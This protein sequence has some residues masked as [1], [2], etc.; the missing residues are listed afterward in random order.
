MRPLDEYRAC[1]RPR[2]EMLPAGLR[3]P[4]A[5]LR[6]YINAFPAQADRTVQPFFRDAAAVI[7]TF[8]GVEIP[9][10]VDAGA[11]RLA[12]CRAGRAGVDAGRARSAPA[13]VDGC[14]ER[15]ERQVG[16]D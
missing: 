8:E 7:A 2:R 15:L 1:D 6:A 4:Y 3:F 11:P 10:P 12:G 13:F 5:P 9:V 16:E 14:G